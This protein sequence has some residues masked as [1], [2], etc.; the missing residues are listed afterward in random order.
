MIASKTSRLVGGARVASA[1]VKASRIW[2]SLKWGVAQAV[3]R[4][5][6]LLHRRHIWRCNNKHTGTK[7]CTSA[8]LRD[9]QIKTMY[10]TTLT[11]VATDLEDDR[12]R[13]DLAT[14]FT[15][16]EFEEDRDQMA[17]RQSELA[18]IFTTMITYNQQTSVDQDD[19]THRIKQVEDEY[20]R[21]SVRLKTIKA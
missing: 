16:K 9:H 4:S 20:N 8:T 17:K 7:V 12:L 5:C 21:N 19:Y 6:L 10:L 1:L 3:E 11:Q 15:T 2:S 14:V 18:A 13:Q